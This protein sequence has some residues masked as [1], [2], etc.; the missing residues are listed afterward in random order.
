[1]NIE[2]KL[3]FVGPDPDNRQP[4]PQAYNIR[5]HIE[6]GVS[7]AALYCWLAMNE[8]S[9]FSQC[10][11][12]NWTFYRDPDLALHLDKNPDPVKILD[13]FVKEYNK[14]FKKKK[15]RSEQNW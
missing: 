9:A 15:K 11:E 14:V 12:S 10:C 13:W 8:F 6:A 4:D 3:R 7:Q 1:M 5:T 2:T